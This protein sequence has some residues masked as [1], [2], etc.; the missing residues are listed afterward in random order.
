M[1][2]IKGVAV[3]FPAGV[4][5]ALDAEAKRRG[6]SRNALIVER[7]SLPD[8]GASM[9]RPAPAPKPTPAARAP[10]PPAPPAPKVE[11][12]RQAL[13]TAEASAAH[14]GKVKVA[15]VV[16]STGYV[17]AKWGDNRAAPGSRLKQRGP[18]SRG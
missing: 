16:K 15:D 11:Q 13:A 8:G 4:L 2:E 17:P 12:A 14:L 7:C 10:A 1:S 9:A 5:D 6:V 18:G 3:R